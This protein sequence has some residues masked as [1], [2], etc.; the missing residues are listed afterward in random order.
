MRK[1]SEV[2]SVGMISTVRA[3]KA[4]GHQ[5]CGHQCESGTMAT[6]IRGD[7]GEASC[8]A[9]GTCAEERRNGLN[10]WCELEREKQDD[11]VDARRS[12]CGGCQHKMGRKMTEPK[13]KRGLVAQGGASWGL[14]EAQEM[15]T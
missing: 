11:N 1:N 10:R 7:G 6:L 3:E 5:R 8:G 9:S 4:V 12:S 2:A 13:W 14:G 15:M